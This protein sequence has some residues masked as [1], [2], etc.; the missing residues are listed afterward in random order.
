MMRSK[1]VR[2]LT[3]NEKTYDLNDSPMPIEI[4]VNKDET[5]NSNRA[6]AEK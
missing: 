4:K 2:N 5:I 3:S 6:N 1:S